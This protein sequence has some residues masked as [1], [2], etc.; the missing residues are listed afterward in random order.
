MRKKLLAL[1]LSCTLI[2]GTVGC[3]DQGTAVSGDNAETQTTA[4]ADAGDSEDTAVPQTEEEAPAE[5]GS[6]EAGEVKTPQDFETFKIGVMESQSN[7]S[8]VL[9]RNYYENYIGPRYNVEFVFS[10]QVKSADDEMNF[11]ENCVDMGV[12]GII[13]FRSSPDVNQIIQVCEEYGLPYSVNTTRTPMVEGAFTGG[14][15]T[16]TGVWGTE[17]VTVS[18]EFKEWIKSVASDD[19]SEGFMVTSALAFQ[20]NTMHAECTQGV[21]AALQDIYG[22]TY[23]DTIEN[24]AA[25]SVPLEVPN[26][27]GI[28]I[29]IYPGTNS[30][31]DNWVQGASTALQTG[32]YGVFLQAA[33][34][35]GYT[36]VAVDEVERGFDMNIKVAVNASISDTLVTAFNTD[37]KFGNPSLDMA[38]VQSVSLLSA[39][40]FVQ[41]YNHLTGYE[42]LNRIENGEPAFFDMPIWTLS[43]REQ[44]N[45]AATW[46]NAE[47]ETWVFDEDAVNAALG[48]YNPDLTNS[49]LND[50]YKSIT[51]DWVMEHMN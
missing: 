22:L 42:A 37:D 13:S 19:G 9:R 12:D 38:T 48:I 21:L 26:D 18:N 34:T 20:G 15:Q 36:G 28:N 10:E 47:K 2:M 29:Y 40:G 7:D 32:K 31:S 4:Q 14:Y 24:L 45:Q 35:Y 23:E 44:V 46:D 51:L 17:P 25:T 8:T 16:M 33:P 27:K 30:T 5:E 49:Q 43:T 41:V 3:G 39:M 6:E 11:I 1:V 50:Y